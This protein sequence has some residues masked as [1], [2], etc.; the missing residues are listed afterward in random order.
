M[1]VGLSTEYGYPLSVYMPEE[2]ELSFPSINIHQLPIGPKIGVEFMSSSITH[3][4]TLTDLILC[5]AWLHVKKWIWCI[6]IYVYLHI[7]NFTLIFM[8]KFI[9]Q[10]YIIFFFS[11]GQLSVWFTLHGN[12]RH[13]YR[14]DPATTFLGLP[15]T[16]VS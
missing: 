3:A 8:I 10:I 4:G 11:W 6:W 16:L 13:L 2:K 15:T 7:K 14:K 12:L 5:K 9:F 1:G